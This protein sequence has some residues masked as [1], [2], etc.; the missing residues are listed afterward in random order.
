MQ[1]QLAL[2]TVASTSKTQPSSRLQVH[3]TLDTI[4]PA[5]RSQAADE[6]RQVCAKKKFLDLAR[7]LDQELTIKFFVRGSKLPPSK[8]ERHREYVQMI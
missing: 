3:V 2:V 8:L 7:S 5:S 6:R 1:H 4:R